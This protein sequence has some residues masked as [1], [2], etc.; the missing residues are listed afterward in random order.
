MV[1]MESTDPEEMHEVLKAQ[2]KANRKRAHARPSKGVKQAQPVD[3]FTKL[4]G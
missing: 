1:S 2:S 4:A 3:R